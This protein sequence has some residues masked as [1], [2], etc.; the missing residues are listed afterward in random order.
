MLQFSDMKAKVSSISKFSLS[1][2]PTLLFALT[3]I[4]L[5]SLFV[6]QETFPHWAITICL[7]SVIFFLLSI[8]LMYNSF[9]G[10]ENGGNILLPIAT[11]V[12]ATISYF[13]YVTEV[14]LPLSFVLFGKGISPVSI[15]AIVSLAPVVYLASTLKNNSRVIALVASVVALGIPYLFAALSRSVS[16]FSEIFSHFVKPIISF[17]SIYQYP[18]WYAAAVLLGV[19]MNFLFEARKTSVKSYTL[20]NRITLVVLFC[21]ALGW[22][23]HNGFRL[24]AGTYYVKAY[25]AASNR[26]LSVAEDNLRKAISI[27]PF[28]VYYLG[29]VDVDLAR[30]QAANAST[31]QEEVVKLVANMTQNAQAAFTYDPSNNLPLFYL[32]NIYKMV[33]LKDQEELVLKELSNRLPQDKDIAEALKAIESAK[34]SNTTSA[35]TNTD[36]TKK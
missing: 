14:N 15:A 13:A 30:L 29:L 1:N 34:A 32:Y 26:E 2:L 35:Q 6:P 3:P 23:L 18:F 22:V 21:L 9:R 28:D 7:A 25:T 17:N 24:V 20:L 5:T 33:G 8:C 4:L 31:T 12:L 19:G 11:L 36:T 27:A 10:R 16:S